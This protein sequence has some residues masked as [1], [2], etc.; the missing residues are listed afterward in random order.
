MFWATVMNQNTKV[1]KK[2]DMENV[3]GLSWSKVHTNIPVYCLV[4]FSTST[5]KREG[6][7]SRFVK[8]FSFPWWEANSSTSV[9]TLR[10][11]PGS[12]LNGTLPREPCWP[13][14]SCKSLIKTGNW[15]TQATP[16]SLVMSRNFGSQLEPF[17]YNQLLWPYTFSFLC[18]WSLDKFF[19]I[20]S[21]CF[22]LKMNASS[23]W[24][25]VILF[26]FSGK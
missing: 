24:N 17:H 23:C 10:I 20:L 7:V 3:K 8:H 2:L 12:E 14:H 11:C 6:F 25:V 22:F 16:Q 9:V 1:L 13:I 21:T 19:N 18:L 5:F 26:F 4:F 15:Q